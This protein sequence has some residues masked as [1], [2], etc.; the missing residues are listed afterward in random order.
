MD[1]RG[2]AGLAE[3]ESKESKLAVKYCGGCNGGRN[4]QFRRRV[5]WKVGLEGSES[6]A[7]F[8]LFTLP[9]RLHHKAEKRV[10]PPWQIPKAP[11]PYNI[12]G[13]LRQRNMAPMKNRSKL[14]KKS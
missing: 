12:T 13:A 8:P 4:S 5:R 1:C 9:Y 10:A 14:Q 7:L 6:P 11:P 3:W 2:E